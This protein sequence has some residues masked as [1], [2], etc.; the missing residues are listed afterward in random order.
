MQEELVSKELNYC[1]FHPET[2]KSKKYDKVQSS[3]KFV[4]ESGPESL[5]EFSENLKEQLKKKQERIAKVRK[6]REY[7]Q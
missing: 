7:E 6:E 5:K 1:T 2:T 3:Y 4:G